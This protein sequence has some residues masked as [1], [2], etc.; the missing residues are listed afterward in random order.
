MHDL[1][2]PETA[3]QR[4]ALIEHLDN[5]IAELA[6]QIDAATYRLLTLIRE[7]DEAGGW[8]D[9]GARSCAHWLSW[10]TN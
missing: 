5:Q 6:A 4:D 10:R 9:G 2:A 1:P 7:F 8:S 3:R